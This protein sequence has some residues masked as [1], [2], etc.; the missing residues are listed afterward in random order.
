MLRSF[1]GAAYSCGWTSF[2]ASH[3]STPPRNIVNMGIPRLTTTLRPYAVS[4]PLKSRQV[5]IDGPALAYHIYYTL[6]NSRKQ[7]RN[8][9]EAALTH[10]ELAHCALLWLDAL[11]ANEIIMFVIFTSD[12]TTSLTCCS[13]QIC[14]DGFLPSSK[15]DTRIERLIRQTQQLKSYH[16]AFPIVPCSSPPSLS[17][18]TSVALSSS[19]LDLFSGTSLPERLTRLPPPPFTVP[20]I[21]KA[22]RSSTDYSSVTKVVPGEADEYCAKFLKENGGIALTG[23]SDFLVYDI[24]QGSVVFL[25][26][27]EKDESGIPKGLLY[28]P[29]HIAARLELPDLQSF[30]FELKLDAYAS[31]PELLTRTKS[32]ESI[33]SYPEKFEH[34]K[35]EYVCELGQPN[36]DDERS[37]GV[38]QGLDPRIS[39]YILQIPLFAKIAGKTPIESTGISPHIFIPFIFGSPA[40]TSPW[41]M[42]QTVRQLAYGLVNLIL[43]PDQVIST[44][45]EH[46]M[47]DT[48]SPGRELQLP[49]HGIPEACQTLLTLLEQVQSKLPRLSKPEFWIA[50]AVCEDIEWSHQRS[51]SAIGPLVRHQA[52]LLQ[53]KVQ[54]NLSWDILQFV[55]QIQSTHYSF[56]ILKLILSLIVL[57]SVDTLPQPVLQLEILLESLP[58]LA[59]F[60]E[61]GQALP[62]IKMIKDRD[63]AKVAHEILGIEVPQV[64]AT[65]Q[66][67]RREAKRKRKSQNN[68]TKKESNRS[69]N[70]FALLETD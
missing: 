38:L 19:S 21:L 24:G 12:S 37:L 61:L 13:A 67:S 43:P 55:A 46:R 10:I 34:F 26:D 54:K 42:S 33:K 59:D 1:C 63:I 23:D 47:Q 56:R 16:A 18:S 6:L 69:S 41:E 35:K 27:I 7:S 25:K 22:L 17:R 39:E 40:K 30:A 31:F 68:V 57:R 28:C 9:F 49:I 20:A 4:E 11:R 29:T 66:V 70:P 45:F 52:I 14:F 50:V 60:P 36:Y 32:F 64:I 58:P 8:Q 44:V 53:D 62:I 5:V 48:Q 65:P 2:R 51:K 3:I 15:Y